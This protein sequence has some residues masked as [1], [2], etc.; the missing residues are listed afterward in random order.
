MN[1]QPTQST[2]PVH[3]IAKLCNLTPARCSQLANEKIMSKAGHGQYHFIASITGY[4]KYLQDIVKKVDVKNRNT[5]P[6]SARSRIDDAKARL[7]EIK[8]A[9]QQ[10]N[11]VPLDAAVRILGDSILA[12]RGRL[13]ALETEFDDPAIRA[14]VRQRIREVL[15]HLA[16]PPEGEVRARIAAERLDG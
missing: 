16:A 8:L 14:K 9:E 2:V 10:Q 13:L 15:A 4:I 6:R 7:A 11:L 1:T 12:A 5:D 3:T